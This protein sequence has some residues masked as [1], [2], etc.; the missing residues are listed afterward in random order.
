[1]KRALLVLVLLASTALAQN[2][3]TLTYRVRQGDTIEVVAAEYYGDK[4]L[5]MFIITE[6]R[7]LEPK[8][9]KARALRPGERLR[10]PATRE[11]ATAKG[12][13]FDQLAQI[14]LGDAKRAQFLA[15]YNNLPIDENLPAG[16]P[17]VVPAHVTHIAQNGGESLTAIAQLYYG[18]GKQA[19]LLKKYN[20]LD[21]AG[22]DKGEAIIVPLLRAKSTKTIPLDADGKDRRDKQKKAIADAQLALPKA[23]GAWMVG[24]FED[25]KAALGKLTDETDFLDA[26]TAVDIDV[27]LGKAHVA[28]DEQDAA[29]AA[30]THAID[31]RPRYTLAPY[32][33]SPKVL[34]AWRKAGGHVEG[35]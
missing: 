23:R 20:G 32:T 18:D 4:S 27:L 6:N 33:D 28:F 22:I 1:M 7:L 19:E 35:E 15:D 24:D 5:A 2:D 30:F 12:D 29:V 11:I 21:K 34:A 25:V 10:V 3:D 17:L 16:T 13:G 26:A 14:Y 9:Y 31:R 8:Q